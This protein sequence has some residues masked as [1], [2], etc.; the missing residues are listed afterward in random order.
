MSKKELKKWE[1]K[2]KLYMLLHPEVM[3]GTCLSCKYRP[4]NM[5]DTPFVRCPTFTLCVDLNNFKKGK[6]MLMAVDLEMKKNRMFFKE[7]WCVEW[8]RNV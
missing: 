6:M 5:G 4:N 3:Q 7:W 2:F 8:I 1:N